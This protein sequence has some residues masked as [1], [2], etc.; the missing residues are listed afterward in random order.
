MCFS[1]P[2]KYRKTVMKIKLPLYLSHKQSYY[3]HHT[4][5]LLQ[6]KKQRKGEEG[7][8]NKEGISAFRFSSQTCFKK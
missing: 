2:F 4:T 7:S 3:Y 5:Q 8:K 1:K 6:L